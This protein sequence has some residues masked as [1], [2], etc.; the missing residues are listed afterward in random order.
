MDISFI[1]RTGLPLSSRTKSTN[2][3]NGAPSIPSIYEDVHNV[4]EVQTE[5]TVRAFSAVLRR[6]SGGVN[7]PSSFDPLTASATAVAAV[8]LVDNRNG[9]ALILFC[10]C[11]AEEDKMS[12]VRI[13]T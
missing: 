2:E 11:M 9:L 4:P 13:H 10:V 5:E 6:I 7:F 8:I 1:R 3:P 12:R